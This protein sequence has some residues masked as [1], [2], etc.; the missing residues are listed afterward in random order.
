VITI[1]PKLPSASDEYTLAQRRAID[2]ELAEAAKGPFYGP[3]D[4]MDGM[5]EHL[6]GQLKK[7]RSLGKSKPLR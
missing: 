1:L 2:G 4:T 3:F 6:Q 7:R 5:V